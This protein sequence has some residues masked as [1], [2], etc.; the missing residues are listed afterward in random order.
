MHLFKV[1]FYGSGVIYAVFYEQR[2]LIPFASI[3]LLY[4]LFS[5]VLLPNAKDLTVRKKVRES[6]F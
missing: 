1:A 6:Q 4:V 3:V 2:I 5:Y